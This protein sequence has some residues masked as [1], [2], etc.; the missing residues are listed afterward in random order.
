MIQKKYNNRDLFD[1]INTH[2]TDDPNSL[3][4][5]Y[6]GKTLN[7][8]LNFAIDQIINR[9][10]GKKKLP[11]FIANESFLFPSTISYEQA[12]DERV[13][14]FHASL[15][16]KDKSV[17]DLTS[18][19]GIDAMTISMAGNHVLAVEIDRLKSKILEHNA[20]ILH[21]NNFSVSNEDCL[22]VI[23]SLD[24]P[25]DFFFIDPARRD[26]DNKRTYAFSDCVPDITSFYKDLIGKGS[27][28]LIKASP[29][30]DI[31]SVRSQFDN[32]TEIYVVSVKN[33]CK[34]I[35]IKIAPENTPNIEIIGVDLDDTGII[36]SFSI[37]EPVNSIKDSG[38]A[39]PIA[40]PDEIRE[41]IYLYEPNS[42]VM[43]MNAAES[44]CQRFDMMKKVGKSTELYISP[45]L[46][47]SFPGRIIRINRKL[48]SS[49]LKK[50]KRGKYSIVTRNYPIKAEQLRKKIGVGEDPYNFIY[51]MK[52]GDK[53]TPILIEGTKI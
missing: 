53:N 18:G 27:I 34:E 28:L 24:F 20:E 43:K 44:I 32:I 25:P 31:S 13:A 6:K 40:D 49:D 37:D 17:V 12:S 5:K 1:F 47:E 21:L 10:K 46:H 29:L 19:L 23:R 35:L 50:M 42:S 41:D 36:S 8:D 4:M 45:I 11:S 3:L 2:L 15:I 48:S 14:R 22:N 30:L 51:G 33:E 39:I 7:F 16:G 9:K 52:A 26:S 38:N